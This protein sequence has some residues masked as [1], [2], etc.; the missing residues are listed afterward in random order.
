MAFIP[1]PSASAD[2]CKLTW[3]YTERH[4]VHRL[5]VFPGLWVVWW[6]FGN[7]SPPLPEKIGPIWL[8][9][10][11]LPVNSP[12]APGELR[13]RFNARGV[14]LNRNWGCRWTANPTWHNQI[15]TGAGGA[16]TF[17]EP[18]TTTLRDFILARNPVAV[19]FWEAR[20]SGGLVSAGNCHDRPRVSAAIAGIYGLAAGYAIADFENLT[21]QELNGDSTNWLDD[22]GIPAIS[23][24]LPSYTD[25]D[26][27]SNLA[28]IRALLDSFGQ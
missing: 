6:I 3:Q 8:S 13:G 11:Q 4:L 10:Y 26:W 5:H 27:I 14:D 20:A 16:E 1:P 7:Y 24:L 2:S 17:S 9:S 28:G 19:V 21:N 25:A 18:E 12:S 22:Q 15:V 23:V